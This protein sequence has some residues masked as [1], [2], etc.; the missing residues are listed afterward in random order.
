MALLGLLHVHQPFGS[1]DDSDAGN[2]F[3]VLLGA[4]GVSRLGWH[5]WGTA[6]LMVQSGSPAPAPEEEPSPGRLQSESGGTYVGNGTRKRRTEAAH[7]SG[8]RRWRT[9]MARSSGAQR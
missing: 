1:G 4:G 7:G 3:T 5:R 8:A 2:G 6:L 9:A